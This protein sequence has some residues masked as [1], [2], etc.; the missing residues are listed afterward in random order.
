MTKPLELDTIL[1]ELDDNAQAWV[2][3]DR[4]SGKYLIIPD[5]RFPGRKPVRFFMR[6][7]DA[8]GLLAEV[9][10]ANPSLRGKDIYPTR[11]ALVPALRGIASDTNPNNA[12]SF[13]VHS[14]N[15][16]YEFLRD[17]V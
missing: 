15:E 10:G 13:V 14:P 1:S 2:L 11:V 4:D 7:E 5:S 16:V 12:D 9:L 6:R 17:R 8:E 3:Q